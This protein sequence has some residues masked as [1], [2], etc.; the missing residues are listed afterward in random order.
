MVSVAFRTYLAKPDMASA[1]EEEIN[2]VFI[3]ETAMGLDCSRYYSWSAY[4]LK[5]IV[6]GKASQK[7]VRD[8]VD[9][10]REELLKQNIQTAEQFATTWVLGSIEALGNDAA[11]LLSKSTA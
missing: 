5:K 2:Q 9:N 6:P 11:N 10:C 7:K 8:A 4:V 1:T 3:N